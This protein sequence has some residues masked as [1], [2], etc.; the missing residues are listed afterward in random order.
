[1]ASDC[2]LRHLFYS[3]I[4][5]VVRKREESIGLRLGNQWRD[6]VI[7]LYLALRGLLIIYTHL[8]RFENSLWHYEYL[9]LFTRT[10][11][12]LYNFLLVISIS[13]MVIFYYILKLGFEMAPLAIL[14]YFH[15][16]IVDNMDTY[17]DCWKSRDKIEELR[18]SKEQK[19]VAR[20][21]SHSWSVA[22]PNRLIST[23]CRM[24]AKF[25]VWKAME[26]VEL[27]RMHSRPMV[28]FHE[29]AELNLRV[30]LI[31]AVSLIDKICL[32]LQISICKCFPKPRFWEPE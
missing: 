20:F 13:M 19:L 5:E 7:L 12:R 28:I 11:P 18:Q 9:L 17:Y 14:R 4:A 3:T 8:D 1:M 23:Y 25:L 27:C 21:Y 10:N 24:K 2:P 16:L 31:R 26:H 32:V 30:I 6:L 22:L 29:E 15:L